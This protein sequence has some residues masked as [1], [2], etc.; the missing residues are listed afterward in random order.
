MQIFNHPII[1]ISGTGTGIG[2]TMA[3]GWLAN[4]APKGHRVTTQKWVQSGDL[5]APDIATHDAIIKRATLLPNPIHALR[6]VY[7]F[8][9]PASPHLAAAQ[10]SPPVTISIQ[11]LLDHTHALAAH[12]DTLLVETSGGLMVPLNH[13]HTTLDAM[14]QLQAPTILVVPNQ[15]GAINHALL[16]LQA[17]AAVKVPVLGVV[18]NNAFDAPP[19]I[20]HDN[21]RIISTIG[22]VPVIGEL[23]HLNY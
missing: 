13:T 6:T 15:L 23:P 22:K 7:A 8:D 3:T 1:V 9:L 12:V 10:A 21:P 18:M 17:L 16:S 5:H 20:Q 19:I 11:T 2:K 4:H 14:T